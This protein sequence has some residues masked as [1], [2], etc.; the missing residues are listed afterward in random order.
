MQYLLLFLG[1][2]GYAN[3]A[4]DYVI[5]TLLLRL[6]NTEQGTFAVL[7]VQSFSVTLY[8]FQTSYVLESNMTLRGGKP[9]PEP[10]CGVES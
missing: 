2:N 9:F 1:N 3:A 5:H 4:K 10:W 7:G 6:E 8:L